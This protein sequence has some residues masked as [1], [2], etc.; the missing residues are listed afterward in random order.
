MRDAIP[1]WEELEIGTVHRMLEM[2]GEYTRQPWLRNVL[3]CLLQFRNRAVE[4]RIRVLIEPRLPMLWRQ[5]QVNEWK[6]A[7]R[8]QRNRMRRTER[9][10]TDFSSA[11]AWK[12]DG[13]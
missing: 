7:Q 11:S 4:E 5:A 13:K 8:R 6:A 1:K 12:E 3:I 2:S 9:E 10:E